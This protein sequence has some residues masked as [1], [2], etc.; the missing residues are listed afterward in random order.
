MVMKVR[1]M[2]LTA[3]RAVAAAVM[4]FLLV[5]AS[6]VIRYRN[7][8]ETDQMIYLFELNYLIATI[9]FIALP[10]GIFSFLIFLFRPV[11]KHKTLTERLHASDRSR[12]VV[13]GLP[14]RVVRRRI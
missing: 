2:R 11:S 8:D 4:L 12:K 6:E 1:R 5:V 13:T 14:P 3:C 9:T 7:M 10:L